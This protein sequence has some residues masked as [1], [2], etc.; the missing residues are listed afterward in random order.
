MSLLELKEAFPS[1]AS[2]SFIAENA[3]V[4]GDVTVGPKSSIWYGC[5]IRGDVNYIRIGSYTNIQ[6]CTMIH[7][8][9]DEKGHTEIGNYVT[10][11]HQCLL[12]ACTLMDETF[13]GMGSIIMDGTIMESGSMVAAGSLV[14]SNR[15]I[16]SGELW[17]GRPAKFA[18][19]L[20][21]EEISH[22]KESAVRYAAL[23]EKYI[24]KFT[25]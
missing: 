7:V 16:K 22:I 23:A 9:H 18:R 5:N 3:F 8:N 14:T 24:K 11:G 13:V 4:I 6:D 19:I 20:T 17:L 25:K 15:H 21:A 10:V 12:H 2:S 1:I